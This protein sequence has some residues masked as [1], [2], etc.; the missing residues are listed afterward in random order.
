MDQD[1]TTE[2]Q[3]TVA[4]VAHEVDSNYAKRDIKIP[5]EKK[6]TGLIV[7]IIVAVVVLLCGGLALWFFAWYSNPN[8]VAYDAV[9]NLIQSENV[10]FEGGITILNSDEDS[11]LDMISIAFDS[12]SSGLPNSSA[13]KVMFIF[14][15]EQVE[16]DPQILIEVKNVVMRDGVIYLQIGGIMDSINS[17]ELDEDTRSSLEIFLSTVEVIDN[18]WW[19]ISIPD[20]LET[21]ELPAEQTNIFTEM[22]H[23]ATQAMTSDMSGEAAAIY[24][25]NQF[26]E[27]KPSKRLAP[28]VESATNELTAGH[29]AYELS[30]NKAKMASFVNRLP[31]TKVAEDFFACYND[32]ASKYGGQ[33][34][35]ASDFDEIT[36]DDVE[37]P[38]ADQL[39]VF[40]E[41]SQFGHKLR[42][43]HFFTYDDDGQDAGGG[44]VM[45]KYDAVTVTPPESYRPIT[46]LFDELSEI[47]SQLFTE[48]IEDSEEYVW[49]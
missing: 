45:F 24:K 49:D 2:D 23:C 41:I 12:A 3:E 27:I 46:D 43:V 34:I 47:F 36:A 40:L 4:P 6:H 32:V 13:A 25:Q 30:I 7:G 14:D 31:E 9:N 28:D 48:P 21:M 39:R 29:K 22:Y 10:G 44:T 19:Q 33:R 35:S 11:P 20:L 42:S 18:E 26:V 15:A 5:A 1:P 37:W 38:D 17:L 8:Q 16:G